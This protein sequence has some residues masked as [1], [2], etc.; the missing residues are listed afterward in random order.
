SLKW[1]PDEHDRSWARHRK[2]RRERLTG[3]LYGADPSGSGSPWRRNACPDWGRVGL[4][5]GSSAF[6]AAGVDMRID[7]SG[8]AELLDDQEAS[9]FHQTQALAL[10][11]NVA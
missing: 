7:F 6:R 3:D 1:K 10:V 4:A 11:V 8:R 5:A 2:C 9:R